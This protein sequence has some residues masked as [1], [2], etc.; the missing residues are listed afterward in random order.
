MPALTPTHLV[1]RLR[2]IWREAMIFL[3]FKHL[4][5]L[6]MCWFSIAN[7]IISSLLSDSQHLSVAPP[8]HL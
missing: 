7:V 2:Q 6:D 4:S 3:L 8:T 1:K 5:N